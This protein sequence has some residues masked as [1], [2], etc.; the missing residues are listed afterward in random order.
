[1][2]FHSHFI[3]IQIFWANPFII[4]FT[5]HYKIKNESE[6]KKESDLNSILLNHTFL[7]NHFL[8]FLRHG[9]INLKVGRERNTST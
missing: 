9:I 6:M 3:K 5:I 4:S 8:F 2:S 1:M 7:S